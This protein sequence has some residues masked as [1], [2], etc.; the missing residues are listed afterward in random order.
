MPS[1]VTSSQGRP[2]Q[3]ELTEVQAKLL[4]GLNHEAVD[5]IF[6]RYSAARVLGLWNIWEHVGEQK[7]I[8]RPP[9]WPNESSPEHDR[10]RRHNNG[11]WHSFPSVGGWRDSFCRTLSATP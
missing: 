5:L 6:A 11:G 9:R 10:W 8:W 7:V 3:S 1:S 4:S 2:S